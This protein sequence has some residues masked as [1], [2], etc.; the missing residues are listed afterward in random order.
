MAHNR[1][2]EIF[3]GKSEFL[4]FKESI[5][6]RATLAELNNAFESAVLKTTSEIKQAAVL[7]SGGVDSSL[8]AKVVA[9]KIPD[10]TLYTAGMQD[11]RDIAEAKTSA[12]KLGLNL[13]TAAISE[14]DLLRY[15]QKVKQILKNADFLQLQI[16]VPLYIAME[17]IQEDAH[18]VVF[19]GQGADELFCGY[20]IF[21]R[22]LREKGYAAVQE[23][24][25]SK[26][27]NMRERNLE[28]DFAVAEHFNLELRVPFLEQN[29][30]KIALAISP[31]L[32]ISS[33]EDEKRK[34]ILREL[35]LQNGIP[36]EIAYMKKRSIQY[37][38]GMSRKL[39]ALEKR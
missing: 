23:E 4:K 24:I 30:M 11:S 29:F 28:R 13:K 22:I 8:I 3:S 32:K 15:L 2:P 7:F 10:T 35:A 12:E 20:D 21:K 1:I 27:E 25:L 6:E 19:C 9:E 31:E 5:P 18:R 38:S 16:A 26:I 34:L 17:K 14:S 39:K 36:Q 37:G 33:P